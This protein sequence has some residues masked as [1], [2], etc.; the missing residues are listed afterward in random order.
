MITDHNPLLIL[1]KEQRLSHVKHL[2]ESKDGHYVVLAA[3]EYNIN[4]AFCPTASHSNA[5]ALNQLLLQSPND[6]V[7]AAPETVL[8][9]EQLDNGPFAP[10]Q[11]KY[12]TLFITGSNIYTKWLA[13][14][15]Q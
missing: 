2:E 3:Y 5:D 12:F 1:F 8:L 4:I 11:V 13:R 7:P 9:L 14:T 15:C 10:Q 6:P